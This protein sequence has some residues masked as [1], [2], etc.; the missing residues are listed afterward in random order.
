MQ[1]LTISYYAAIF[2]EGN[3]AKDS[4]STI[5]SA[6]GTTLYELDREDGESFILTAGTHS[7]IRF[8]LL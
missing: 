7:I 1:T 3:N 5:E 6:S 2:R 4:N 8:L